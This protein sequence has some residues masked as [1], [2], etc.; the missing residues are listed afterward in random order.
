MKISRYPVAIAEAAQAVNAL[1]QR[2][3]ELRLELARQEG[4]AD[5]VVAFEAGLKN[6]N[7]RKARRF[8]LLDQDAEYQ[9]LQQLQAQAITDK[10]NAIAQLEYL[11]NQFGVAK[12]E[13]RWAIAEKLVGLETRELVGL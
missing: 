13:V 11:R 10:S 7:Q 5:L 6:D 8:E 12:L 9:R 4:K 1:E 3:T 2:L